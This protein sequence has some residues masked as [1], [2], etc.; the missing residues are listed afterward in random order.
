MQSTTD[1]QAEARAA[2]A[3]LGGDERIEDAADDVGRDAFAVVPDADDRALA[4]FRDRDPDVAALGS[5]H[6][7]R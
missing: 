7:A 2:L 6:R 1:G 3:A 5:R 4:L